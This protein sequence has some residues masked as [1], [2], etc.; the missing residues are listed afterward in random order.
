M[1]RNIFEIILD[2]L[3]QEEKEK[4]NDNEWEPEPLH[5]QDILPE[6]APQRDEPFPSPPPNK[7]VIIIDL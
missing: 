3:R 2:L 6:D 1:T 7:K 5:M 4:I